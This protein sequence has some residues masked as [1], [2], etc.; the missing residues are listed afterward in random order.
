MIPVINLVKSLRF[1]LKDMQGLKY[2]D[3]ELIEAVNQAV[4]L[5]NNN[6]EQ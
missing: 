6:R 2:S 3:Y 1:A 4:S 5:F